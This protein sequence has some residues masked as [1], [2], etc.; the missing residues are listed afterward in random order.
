MVWV[1]KDF[2][3]NLV[4]TSGTLGSTTSKPEKNL[5]IDIFPLNCSKSAIPWLHK[6]SP[7][8]C[9][10]SLLSRGGINQRLIIPRSINLPFPVMKSESPARHQMLQQAE[11]KLSPTPAFTWHRVATGCQHIKSVCLIANSFL[12]C[13]VLLIPPG[14]VFSP[15]QSPPCWCPSQPFFSQSFSSVI[16]WASC[17][18][19]QKLKVCSCCLGISLRFSLFSHFFAFLEPGSF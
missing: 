13:L 3:D 6:M 8:W 1:G 16:P 7:E 18:C 17:S 11:H 10:L 19:W 2:K 4:T 12:L 9:F 5:N 15:L 14:R